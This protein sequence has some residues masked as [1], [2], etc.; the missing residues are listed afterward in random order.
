MKFKEIIRII[1][2]DGWYIERQKGSHRQYKH[3]KKLGTVTIAFHK[4]SDEIAKGTL[5][6]VLKQAQIK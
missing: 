6:S 2:D 3:A 5:S 4:I 1:E